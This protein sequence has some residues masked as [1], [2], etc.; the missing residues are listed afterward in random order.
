[1]DL[2]CCS[3]DS[4]ETPGTFG[5]IASKA[6]NWIVQLL[7]GDLFKDKGSDNEDEA[8]NVIV[9]ILFLVHVTVVFFF[10]AHHCTA[11]G[12]TVGRANFH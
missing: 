8:Q 10:L 4:G 7:N 3:G 12:G 5:Q 9:S 11:R 6:Q 1:M 2:E